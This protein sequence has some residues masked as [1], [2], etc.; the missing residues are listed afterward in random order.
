ML[1]GILF[2]VDIMGWTGLMGW[3]IGL[4]GWTWV[5]LVLMVESGWIVG[6]GV[7]GWIGWTV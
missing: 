4:M 5:M 7:I 2:I 3:T 6:M 1:I